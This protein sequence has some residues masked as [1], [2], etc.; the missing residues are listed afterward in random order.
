MLMGS[1]KAVAPI[2]SIVLM[3]L[4]L[5]AMGAVTWLFISGTLQRIFGVEARERALI[6]AELARLR[7]ES[8]Q[9]DKVIIRNIGSIALQGFTIFA[10]GA[11]VAK[12]NASLEPDE[13]L[14]IEIPPLI[15]DQEHEVKV[16]SQYASEALKKIPAIIAKG[17]TYWNYRRKI[18]IDN[19]AG[20]ENLTDFQ[21]LLTFNA[22]N[23][24]YSKAY[25]S[26][27]R[28]AQEL[29]PDL[30]KIPYYLECFYCEYPNRSDVAAWW[31]FNDEI[32]TILD[33]SGNANHGNF[34]GD[35]VL[36]LHF[37]EGSGNYA[38]DS[39]SYE[40]DGVLYNGTNVCNGGDC[41][42]W[43]SNTP[44]GYGYAIEFDGDNDY[45]SI[46]DSGGE[47]LPSQLTVEA[48][49]Y[50]ESTIAWQCI[51]ERG[52]PTA[53]GWHFYV[54]SG[55]HLYTNIGGEAFHSQS[56]T[57]TP[58]TWYHVAFVWDGNTITHY[59]NG[60]NVGSALVTSLYT[61]GDRVYIG[62]RRGGGTD[63]LGFNGTIDEVAIYN[64]ALSEAEIRQRYEARKAKFIEFVESKP[65]LSKAISFDG[66]DD[67]VAIPNDPSLNHQYFTYEAWIKPRVSTNT[68]YGPMII[69]RENST[70]GNIFLMRA[71][72]NAS[73]WRRVTCE[74]PCDSG[75]WWGVNYPFEEGKW[76]HVVCWT[77]D[78]KRKIYVNGELIG[79][80]D[81]I[82]DL[83]YT[84]SGRLFIG[85]DQDGASMSDFFNGSI[86]EVRLIARP[87]SEEEI[88]A[89]Y[90][91][92]KVWI[93]LKEIKA[94]SNA[95]VIMYYG[96]EGARSESD[97]KIW[98]P[99]LVGYW[100]FDGYPINFT[101]D[102]SGNENHGT[103][104]GAVAGGGK[105]GSAL[106]FDGV[107]DYVD[108]GN[109][110][111]IIAIT[112]EAWVKSASATGYSGVWQ[113]V[114]KYNAYILGT[115]S[116]GG[117]NVCFIIFDTAWRYG[118]C[119]TVPDPENWH[120]FVGVYNSSAQEKKIYVDGV[121]RGTTNPSGEI[122]SDTGPLHIG[123][124]ECCEGFNFNGIID[125]I[126]IYNRS[127]SEAEI[128]ARY[129][130]G[131]PFAIIGQEI[132]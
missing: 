115:S 31:H 72:I 16:L 46:P 86:D 63:E 110:N 114:S 14:E 4:L 113:I 107:D 21:V 122:N 106:S 81:R 11:I 87:L 30:E 131:P 49:I 58:N 73:G 125:E 85:Q 1:K 96:N 108:C 53:T 56:G 88:K 123:R 70:G 112:V 80:T 121:L 67:Y 120:Y 94:N 69:M 29:S 45:I 27:L 41:P 52:S 83:N 59:V 44:A 43:V 126:R 90:E 8:L 9:G 93:R 37:D 75:G 32:S 50:T 109:V 100:S 82:C 105:V 55:N 51:V 76:Y 65:D 77:N 79:E 64:R 15:A 91:N 119:Y 36:L 20:S 33:S 102:L 111:P 25:G 89:D 40:N 61:G 6:E 24:N 128:R 18:T 99:G 3:L 2:I 130:L 42:T 66:I 13:V 22:T 35:T 7:I 12:S 118:S 129:G 26:D 17:P 48:W 124:R 34:Y 95:S 117:D 98:G 28:F 19:Q 92:S 57:I 39:T 101:K 60:I 10:D 38:N 5:V 68:V 103:I 74:W 47:F 132:S 78:T 104:Y 97:P 71:G 62:I 54:S 23:F 84:N 116:V 127:L